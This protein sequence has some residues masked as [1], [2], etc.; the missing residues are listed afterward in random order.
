MKD[1]AIRNLLKKTELANF[2][3][4]PHSKV[5]EELKLPAAKARIDIAVINGHLHGYEIKGASDT[6]QRLPSQV[7]AYSKIFDYLTVVT[8]LKYHERILNVIPEWVGVSVCSDKY[9][10]EEFEIIQP[11]VLNEHKDAFYIA[12]LLWREELIDILQSFQIPHKKKIRS[13]LLCEAAAYNLDIST[14]S[15]VVREK[16]KVRKDWKIKEGYQLM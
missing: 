11:P 5:V 16:L 13:W 14:L 12:K 8:E 2:I 10:N 1:P 6:L 7:N 3:T 9:G 15:N 4:D